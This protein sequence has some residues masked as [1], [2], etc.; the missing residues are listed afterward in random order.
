MISFNEAVSTDANYLSTSE[1]NK[2]IFKEEKKKM[3]PLS[4]SNVG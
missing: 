3:S 4:Y 1:P 2:R